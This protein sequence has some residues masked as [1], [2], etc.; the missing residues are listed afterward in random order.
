[1]IKRIIT[2][3][4]ILLLILTC[5]TFGWYQYIYHSILPTYEKKLSTIAQTRKQEI[6]QY[7]EQ[8]EKNALK[9]AQED[10]ILKALSN[11]PQTTS[12]NT[13]EQQNIAALIAT[14][15]EEMEFKNILLVNKNGK[16]IFSTTKKDLLTTDLNKSEYTN[17]SLGKSHERA[18][19]TLT[20]DFSNFNFNELL[21]EPALFITIP[22]LKEKKF[23]GALSYQLDEEKIYLI[24]NQY[25]GLGKTGEVVV[26]RKDNESVIFLSPTRHDHDLAFKKRALF[27]KHP[28]AIA[29]AV[30][31]QEG[32]GI[33]T[34]YRGK[35]VIGA[36]KFIPKL[37]WGM[38]VKIDHDEAI[39]PLQKTYTLF[40]FLLLLFM[41]C[42]LL[43][44]YLFWHVIHN[45]IRKIDSHWPFNKIPALIKNPLFLLLLL[46]AGFTVKNV[47]ECE[48]KKSYSIEKA[49]QQA[50]ES[51]L[52]NTEIITT[53][54][55][56]IV[57]VGQAIAND[58]HTNYLKKDDI[59]TR[60]TRDATENNMI[61]DITVL[62]TPYG[63]DNKTEIYVQATSNTPAE[64]SNI[65][66]TYWYKQALEK[67]SV[68]I[69]NSTLNHPTE[70]TTATYACTF[71]D[72]DNK[73]NGVVAI[74]FSLHTIISS[75][76]YSG[77]GQ[78]GYS[79]ITND[80][81]E[82]IFHPI[83][84]L[85][86]NQ[87]TLLQFA[88][89]NGNEE[90]A[91]IAVQALEKKQLI[92]SYYSP[93]TKE[94]SWIVTQTIPTNNWVIGIIFSEDEV[95]LAAQKIRHYYFWI[96]LWLIITLLLLSSLLYSFALIPES[97]Y[98]A[99]INLILLLG[100]IA[101]WYTITITHTISRE[102][103]TVITD[104]SSLDKFLNDL[105]EEAHRKHEPKPIN[106]PC[107]LLLY[108]L[109]I[110]DPDHMEISGYLWTKYNAAEHKNIVHGVDILQSTR[111]IVGK[112]LTSTAG[113]WETETWSVQGV[114]S[115]DQHNAQ[116][117]FDQQQLRIILEHRD[118]EKNIILTP[119]LVAY[120]KVSPESTPGLDKEF[121]ISGFTVEQTF[122]EY[123]NTDPKADFGFKEYG[124][125][126]DHF[127]LIYNVILNRN[128][129]NPFVLYVLPLLVILF[130]LFCTLLIASRRTDPF[131]MLGPY[132]GLFFSLIVLQRSL[133]EQHPS[134]S[135]LYIEYAFFY[136][137]V[138][139]ILLILHTILN[140]F[141]KH[142]SAYQEKIFHMIK[143][144]F[145]PFQFI[146]WLITTLIVFY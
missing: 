33:G 123:R 62:F 55:E 34:D 142:K 103:I 76:E 81:G 89:S 3:L 22:I 61:T 32:S 104:Q 5:G 114:L 70:K 108:T 7:L 13:I 23:I 129:L 146:T 14:H 63:Y 87:T 78:T 30:L 8:Q 80:T 96:L 43:N 44:I 66:E 101:T 140:H 54:L 72:K 118:L 95:E 56:K 102:A 86:R 42:L 139:I 77:I 2:P 28:I 120:K 4:S 15:K 136:T 92:A 6:N 141:Y 144:L 79:F 36:W 60:L 45:S 46:A 132:T 94:K 1:M 137:Y 50:V 47:I 110:P 90:L 73:P 26:G 126:T 128:I 68:W 69:V 83:A 91:S 37:D 35:K 59:N 11:A 53:V 125:V 64:T 51:N 17:S 127:Q 135:T 24:T 19:M 112:P 10:S 31:G 40:L 113:D 18:T 134:G 100:L 39:E 65:F 124:K 121:T 49:Q 38:I 82:F 16:I 130:T 145:W 75:A 25:I 97:I 117:P 109:N 52:K 20:N 138:T 29:A 93:A 27:I 99:L 143:L 12:P 115:Q 57:V 41:T 98:A 84:S 131:S 133:R 107:G 116:Y 105:N 9:L 88:Q 21:N 111:I 74:T 119:D 71:F 122:F 48:R 58:L 67:K 106:I 85:V